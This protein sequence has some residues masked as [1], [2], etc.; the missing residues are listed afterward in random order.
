MKITYL[1]STDLK[2][3][4]AEILNLVGFGEMIAIVERYGKPLVKITPIK[5]EKKEEKL[6]KKLSQ[7]FGA[8]PNFPEV[9]KKRN[10]RKR[11]I[12]L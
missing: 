10:F 9:S 3:K 7:Y 1:S 5:E 8:I 6:E 2:R 4:T 11:K 12:I